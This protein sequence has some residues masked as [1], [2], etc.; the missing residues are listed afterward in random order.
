[1]VTFVVVAQAIVLD[2]RWWLWLLA[3]VVPAL[4]AWLFISVGRVKIEVESDGQGGGTLYAGQARL[5]FDAIARS[6]D[7]SHT[8]LA[9]QHA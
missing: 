5:P 7:G 3:V 1:M 6:A 2:A 4:L 8:V 9:H